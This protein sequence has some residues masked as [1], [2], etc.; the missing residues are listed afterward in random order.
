MAGV[1]GTDST[2]FCLRDLSPVSPWKADSTLAAA[3]NYVMVGGDVVTIVQRCARAYPVVLGRP[4]V[5]SR[6]SANTG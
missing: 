4:R 2:R 1:A 3:V 5:I 6:V